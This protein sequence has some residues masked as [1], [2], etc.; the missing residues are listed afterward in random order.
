M[1]DNFKPNPK[2]LI[3]SVNN[4]SIILFKLLGVNIDY[5]LK[6]LESGE[7]KYFV[8]RTNAKN[9]FVMPLKMYLGLN[10][11][12]RK[13]L[14]HLNMVE[15]DINLDSKDIFGL[16]DEIEALKNEKESH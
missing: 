2:E 10:K 11:S 15:I 7:V 3:K 5:K 9:Q 14:R 1:D 8:P 12:I 13:R 6:E 16:I 4:L